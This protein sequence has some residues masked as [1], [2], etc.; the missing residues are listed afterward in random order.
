M[1]SVALEKRQL[2]E[3]KRSV[4]THDNEIPSETTIEI[5][6]PS[7]AKAANS[8]KADAEAA[9]CDEGDARMTD[10]KMLDCENGGCEAGKCRCA[11]R[12][13]S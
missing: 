8:I 6:R 4:M 10:A 1:Y 13:L 12:E 11:D 9:D 5:C 2:A 3:Y 7:A